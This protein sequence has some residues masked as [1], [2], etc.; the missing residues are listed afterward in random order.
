MV[1]IV[2]LMKEHI[3]LVR[4]L[5]RFSFPD[6][7]QIIAGLSL[8]PQLDANAIRI[9]VL[10]HLVAVSCV[11]KVKPER[12]NLSEWL[13]KQMAQ[14][15]AASMEDPVED[16]FVGCVNSDFGSF[17]V[18]SGVFADGDF[19]VERLLRF[20]G[21]KQNFPP[22]EMV[23]KSVLPLLRI[24]DALAN[25]TQ[26]ARYSTG[27]GDASNKIPVPQ[28]RKVL[29]CAQAVY[30]SAADL[31]TLEITPEI[32]SEFT[33]TNERKAQLQAEELWNSSL[34]RYPLIAAAN[35]II[36]ATPTSLVRA[37]I[38][39]CL[40]H[41]TKT[42]GGWADTF[43][44]VETASLFV[45]E[46]RKRLDFGP[47][48]FKPPPWPDGLPSM[49]PY[50]GQFDY[51]KPVIMLTHC[52]ALSQSAAAFNGYE[53]LSDDGK[54]RDYLL[55]CSGELQK[56]SG[57]SGG[58]ILICMAGIGY[59]TVLSLNHDLPN[60]HIH[61]ASLPDWLN[62]TGLGD[63]TARRLWKLGEHEA[64]LDAYGVKT[65]NLSGLVNL[66]AYWKSNG[67]R[68]V[69]RDTDPRS[70]GMLNI[71]CDFAT[72]LRV[73]TKKRK[74]V[75]CVRSHDG[76]RW[77]QL[78]RQNAKP[79]FREDGAIPLYVD[80]DSVA[81]G[82]LVGCIK[83]DRTNWW[84]V[85]PPRQENP[86]FTNLI[87]RLWECVEGWVARLTPIVERAFN[88]AVRSVEIQLDLPSLPNWD[89]SFQ[90][91]RSAH[92]KELSMSG[93]NVLM[94]IVLTM[95]EEFMVKFNTPKNVAE[96]EIVA[97]LLRGTA[98]LAGVILG[99][100]KVAEFTREIMKNDDARF[101]HV[102]QTHSIEQ[103]VAGAGRPEPLFIPEE[104]FSLSQQGIADLVGRPP[105]GNEIVGVGLCKKYLADTVTK[106]WERIETRLN[107]LNR[108]LVVLRCFHA[109]DEV[110]RDE[111]HWDM[112]ARSQFAL[113]EDKQNVHDVLLVRRSDRG[114]ASLCNR[115]I[116]ET[117]QYACL[118]DDGKIFGEADHVAILADMTL[119]VLLASHRDGVAYGFM[120]PTIEIAQN[121]EL[122]VDEKFYATVMSQY[123]TKRGRVASEEAASDYDSYFP[124]VERPDES[125]NIKDEKGL[126]DFDKAFA[127]EFGFSVHLLFRA[128]DEFRTIAVKTD[129]LGGKITEDVMQQVLEVSGFEPPE[130]EAFLRR[131]TLPIRTGWNKDLPPR[132][133]ESDVF[134]WRF[135][136]QLSLNMRPLVQ[137]ST[138]PRAWVISVPTFEKSVTY[139]IG[140]LERARFP[141]E[142]FH[143]EAMQSYVG[144]I[145][146]KRGH[147]FAEKVAKVFG[148]SGCSV[149]LETEVTEIGAP[150]KL[151]L[152]DVDVLSWDKTSGRVYIVECKRLLPATSVREVV[153]RLEEFRGNT[154]EKDSLGRHL[155]R[156]DWL[157]NNAEALAK[158]T[159][160]PREKTKMVPLLVTSDIMPME[161]F[162]GMNFPTSQ[163]LSFDE[164]AERLRR[165]GRG[166]QSC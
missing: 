50:F 146:N 2:E 137:V 112:T 45:N 57:F 160:I 29:A 122:D 71:N 27:G 113:H 163:V 144:H 110:A 41:I 85:A 102:V 80:L 6:T 127:P 53:Q 40:E 63:C 23:V 62:L 65:V 51:G 143:S 166:E 96:A 135:R 30:F 66:Y 129:I 8:C 36:V 138:S 81:K 48:T 73:E 142:F 33:L 55:A 61:A 161:F 141:K 92:A 58:L 5:R 3:R 11:G 76:K 67:F 150:K 12:E 117:A 133:R 134:P 162:E 42:M 10:Q 34:E 38:R 26:M 115:L 83:R 152:G 126:N 79:L 20:L 69:P 157:K 105:D 60:W 39:F 108:E 145:T 158:I 132:C 123:F 84:I 164:L 59:S 154:K 19:W 64:I 22:F 131:F 15:S 98:E 136:R 116:I 28:W 25:R 107:V 68:L 75:H 70:L 148:Q 87:L 4:Q 153:Q 130:A 47:L 119:L 118:Q 32:L 46:V 56:M 14:S 9:E 37:V 18:F 24:S 77:V 43:F 109:L 82:Y 7:A 128:L 106:L 97:A 17:R 165:D 74:D 86:K 1:P 93:D 114:K 100:Q 13:G 124:G 147:A 104:D 91:I 155:R 88:F 90:T 111:K 156:I 139:V 31:S 89:C 72:T 95:P 44:A 54:L 151:G 35:G 52:T 21:E 16:V 49:F 103:I 99:D 78:T 125:A 149:K 140:H 121:G 94:R 159:G 101:F 120:K